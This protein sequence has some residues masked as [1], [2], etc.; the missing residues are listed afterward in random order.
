[1]RIPK[2]TARG[3]HSARYGQVTSLRL[4][5]RGRLGALLVASNGINDEG[6]NP[7][8]RALA[9]EARM[10]E[11]LY[12]NREGQGTDGRMHDQSL[13]RLWPSQALSIQKGAP[14]QGMYIYTTAE[15]YG[16]VEADV[17]EHACNEWKKQD[18]AP[19]SKEN[20]PPRYE[21]TSQFRSIFSDTADRV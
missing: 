6:V 17:H 14:L 1:M 10:M 4:G 18:R 9:R 19:S 13:N 5:A 15:F 11:C 7:L 21:R 12:D 20:L 8:A 16:L 3:T 2:S